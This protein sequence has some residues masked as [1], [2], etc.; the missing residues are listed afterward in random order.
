MTD[1][2]EVRVSYLDV[3]EDGI[4]ETTFH[5]SSEGDIKADII[6]KNVSY[7]ISNQR[8][9]NKPQIYHITRADLDE[10]KR[11]ANEQLGSKKNN[12]ILCYNID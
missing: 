4:D 12:F 6:I 9:E 10:V 8:G 7:K 3:E 11:L 2:E 5:R 1:T